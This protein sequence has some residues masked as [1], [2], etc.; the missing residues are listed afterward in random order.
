MKAEDINRRRFLKAGA[1]GLAAAPMLGSAAAARESDDAAGDPGGD[2]SADAAGEPRVRKF[3]VLGNTGLK[4]SDISLGGAREP[5]VLRYALDCGINLYDTAEQ[6]FQG[7]H[8]ADIGRAFKEVRDKVVVIT[9]HLHGFTHRISKQDVIDRF[10]AS[11]QRMGFDYIDVA[12]LHHLADPEVLANEELLGAYEE[13]K[14]AGKFR[15]FGFSTHDADVVCEKA[16]ESGLFSVMLLIYNSV[17]YPKRS[18]IITKAKENGIGVLAMKTMAGRQQDRIK[19][20]VNERTRFSQA[21]IKWA[22]TDKGVTSVLITMRTF[23]HIEEYLQASG[24]TLTPAEVEVLEKY[25]AAVDS[26][27]CRIGCTAC[28]E[29][30]P[31][32]VAIPDIMRFGMYYENYG[33]ERKAIEEYAAIDESRK[34]HPCSGCAGHCETACPHR[35]AIRDRLVRYDGMLRIC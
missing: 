13:L 23:E 31:S 1:L 28:L 11:L 20:L 34:A 18:E 30:C 33:E 4:V 32:R 17:Q 19:E 26:E 7:Q 29:S 24:G 12:M 6:Y 14:K 3:N 22:L 25:A 5:S 10:D 9:K 8:E 21:A 27:Y 2:A 15:Y 35:L 16:I